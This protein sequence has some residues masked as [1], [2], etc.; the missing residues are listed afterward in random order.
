MNEIYNE[1]G[2]AKVQTKKMEDSAAVGEEKDEVPG[3]E[4]EDVG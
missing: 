4:V 3:F 2:N 1:A